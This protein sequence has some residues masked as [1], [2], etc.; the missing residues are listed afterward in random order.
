MYMYIYIYIYVSMYVCVYIYIYIHTTT[1]W[2]N[3]SEGSAHSTHAAAVLRH[4]TV[5]GFSTQCC[6]VS[7]TSQ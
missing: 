1:T 7:C 4:G 3:A 2:A 6:E 5:T